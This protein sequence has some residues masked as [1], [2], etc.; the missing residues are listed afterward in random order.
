MFAKF[1]SHN[2]KEI[3]VNLDHVTNI[4]TETG[5]TTLWFTYGSIEVKESFEEVKEICC[6]SMFGVDPCLDMGT[7]KVECI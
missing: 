7:D 3:L 1:I 4:S 2:G 6:P 5:H